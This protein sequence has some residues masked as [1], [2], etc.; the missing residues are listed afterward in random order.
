MVYTPNPGLPSGLSERWW[1]TWSPARKGASVME[2]LERD[3]GEEWIGSWDNVGLYEGN[4][5]IQN[6]QSLSV[7]LTTHRLI[8]IPD[9]NDDNFPSSSS[10]AIRIPCL[11]SHLSHVR[12]TEF[13]TGFIRSSPKITLF[14]G[15]VSLPTSKVQEGTGSSSVS[16]DTPPSDEGTSVNAS[17]SRFGSGSTMGASM[18]GGQGEISSWTCRVCGYVNQNT[19][20]N[21]SASKC[22]LC[23]I[24]YRSQTFSQTSSNPPSR[25]LTPLSI[26]TPS[27]STVMTPMTSTATTSSPLSGVGVGGQSSR[28]GNGNGNGNESSP[29]TAMAGQ[30]H[31]NEEEIACPACTFLNSPFLRN[32]EICSTPLPPTRLNT[33]S[34]PRAETTRAA[35]S[36]TTTVAAAGAGSGVEGKM[37]IVRLSFRKGGSQEVYKRLKAVLGDKAWEKERGGGVVRLGTGERDSGGGRA[38]AGIDGILQSIDLNA[39]AQ[40]EHMQSAFADLEALMLRAGEMVRLAQS[41]NNKLTQT[42][43]TSSSSTGGGSGGR[44][45][46]EEATM[47]RTSLVQLGL[48]APA[49]TKEMVRDERRYREGLAK[50]LGGLLTGSQGMGELKEGLMVGE[51]GRGVIGLDEVW[52]LWMRARGVALLA[53]STLIDTLPFLPQHTSPSIQSLTL[54]S[55]LRVL[56][57]PTYSTPV[58]LYRTIDRLTPTVASIPSPSP[59]SDEQESE[60]KEKSFSIFEFASIESLPVGLAQEFLEM[61]ETYDST[62]TST[63]TSSTGGG[64][65]GGGLVRDDQASQGEGGAR[66][67]RDIITSW[68]LSE[69]NV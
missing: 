40:D 64:G 22:A 39:K 23:G 9:S 66:W 28:N 55:S 13:Y 31:K 4:N 47:I 17:G 15:S 10:N 68:P 6:Y 46:E 38:A 25:S 51:K 34:R 7:N 44:P 19:G 42:Q 41:L 62:S 26:P 18:P 2:S 37:D 30:E 48:A 33:T 1:S 36:S 14:L 59:P 54:P 53:P 20:L 8:L 49:L 69:I 52:G 63:S 12:Q 29:S 50:E 24:P 65:A 35:G 27:S 3:Q 61:M 67:Y 11:Q 16:R 43:T 57:T 21:K 56:H 32:C 60:T 45:S 58:I 5:K